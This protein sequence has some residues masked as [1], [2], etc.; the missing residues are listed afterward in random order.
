MAAIGTFSELRESL[1]IVR[2]KVTVRDAIQ[3]AGGI[4]QLLRTSLENA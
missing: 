2:M 4:G 3:R 1:Q